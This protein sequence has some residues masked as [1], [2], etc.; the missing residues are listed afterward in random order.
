M[1]RSVNFGDTLS[2]SCDMSFALLKAGFDL[3][4]SCALAMNYTLGCAM[5]LEGESLRRN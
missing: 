1:G 2:S 5:S 4:A 3:T